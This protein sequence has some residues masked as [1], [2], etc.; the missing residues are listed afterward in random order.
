MYDKNEEKGR[1]KQWIRKLNAYS[2]GWSEGDLESKNAGTADFVN[3]KAR[4]AIE[5]KREKGGCTDNEH[6]N[7]EKLSN[8]IEKY[9]K[10]A[11]KK[12]ESYPGYKTI[13]IIE[14]S[15]FAAIAQSAMSGIRQIHFN[16]MGP[17]SSSIRNVRLMLS[18]KEFIGAIIFWPAPGSLFNQ[19][20]Y[21]D[22]SS[23]NT[24][25]KISR[26]EAEI[27]IGNVLTVM[28]E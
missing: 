21:F 9:I 1:I 11:N 5:L 25:Q 27:I 23:A 15:S 22:N 7:I 12:F 28:E 18:P 26:R 17:T 2:P 8:R 20:H 10:S 13:L 3:H 4:I 16:R 6:D 14:L 19:A 24:V